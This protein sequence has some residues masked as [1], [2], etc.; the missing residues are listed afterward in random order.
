MADRLEAEKAEAVIDGLYGLDCHRCGGRMN[1]E[2]TYRHW[3]TNVMK[4]GPD[5]RSRYWDT[6][7]WRCELC[8]W[9]AW[10]N[11]QTGQRY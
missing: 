9:G 4:R 8:G 2:F 3:L 6:V 11:E 7:L 1:R 5:E 10:I